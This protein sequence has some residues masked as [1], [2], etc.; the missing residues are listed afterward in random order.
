M[1]LYQTGFCDTILKPW[2]VFVRCAVWLKLIMLYHIESE[3]VRY[4]QGLE[5]KEELTTGDLI[6]YLMDHIQYIYIIYE[7]SLCL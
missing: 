2:I 4:I 7:I 1:F 5:K 6:L 3:H